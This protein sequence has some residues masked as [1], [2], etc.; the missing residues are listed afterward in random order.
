[1]NKN[2]DKKEEIT[3]RR[4]KGNKSTDNHKSGTGQ[5]KNTVQQKGNKES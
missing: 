4:A 5:P 1:M 2:L 3:L